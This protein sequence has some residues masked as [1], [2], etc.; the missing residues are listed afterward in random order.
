LQERNHRA[1]PNLKEEEI[2]GQ[3]EYFMVH[4]FQNQERMFAY[5]RKIRKLEKSSANL[6]FFDS[7]GPLQYVEVIGIDRNVGFFEVPLDKKKNYYII[8]KYANW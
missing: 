1:P 4:K 3:I 5:V 2:F 8:D 7:F 6:N